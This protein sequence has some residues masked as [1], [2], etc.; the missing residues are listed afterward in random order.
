M[1]EMNA[2]CSDSL[3]FE[4]SNRVLV[5]ARYFDLRMFF[6]GVVLFL[7]IEPAPESWFSHQ[8]FDHVALL[9]VMPPMKK[10][11]AE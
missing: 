5:T 7:V 11:K 10:P 1:I 8:N 9:V 6:L 2:F 3:S 4:N